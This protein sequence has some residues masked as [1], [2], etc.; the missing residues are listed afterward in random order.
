[1]LTASPDTHIPHDTFQFI[2]ILPIYRD[3]QRPLQFN[4]FQLY[5][6]CPP[7]YDLRSKGWCVWKVTLHCVWQ[8]REEGG[9]R[10]FQNIAHKGGFSTSPSISLSSI[11]IW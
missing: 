1:M 9:Q 2:I 3:Q 8:S 10:C 5:H 4:F 11:I 7:L 6:Y